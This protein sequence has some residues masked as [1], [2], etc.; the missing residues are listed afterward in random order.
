MKDYDRDPAGSRDHEEVPPAERPDSGGR[1]YFEEFEDD[2]F[3]E[4]DRDTDFAA[5]Y[6][7]VEVEEEGEEAWGDRDDPEQEVWDFVEEDEDAYD[8]MEDDTGAGLPPM[9]AGPSQGLARSLL[10]DAEEAEYEEGES[11]EMSFSLGMIVVAVA[12]MLL[13]G[14]GGYGVIKQRAEMKEE[15][16]QLQARLATAAPPAEVAASRAAAEEAIRHSRDLEQQVAQLTRENR[17]LQATVDGLESQLAAQQEA[18]VKARAQAPKAAPGPRPKPAPRPAP[19]P[20]A[21]PDTGAAP[22]AVA[23]PGSGWFVNFSSY[24]RREAAEAWL[25]KL[26]VERGRVVLV[27]GESGG[28]TIYRVRVVDLPDREAAEAVARELEQTFHLQKLWVGQLP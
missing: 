21:V 17:A 1:G 12:A 9:S 28:Q 19:K 23:Q 15:V 6:T 16:R 4:S 18:R 2:A 22:A 20:A 27:T 10:D 13:L 5:M 11:R 26:Q 8:V 25:P 7:E 3:E 24:T 14:V